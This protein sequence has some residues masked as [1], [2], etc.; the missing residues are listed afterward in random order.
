[1][2]AEGRDICNG[3]DFMKRNPIRA[4]AAA[5][6][7]LILLSA[8]PGS[9]SASGGADR[10][11]L[12]LLAGNPN[13]YPLEYYD[14]D[15]ECFSGILPLIMERVAEETGL[16]FRY[17]NEGVGQTQQ[18]IAKNKQADIL[19]AYVPDPDTEEY[20]S[21][22]HTVMSVPLDG[23]TV[24][25]CIAY[26]TIASPELIERVNQAL[27]KLTQEDLA[28]IVIS[29]TVGREAPRSRI[30]PLILMGLGL[31]LAAVCI[32]VLLIVLIKR[33]HR[34][35]ESS[36]TD[37]STGLGNKA[38]FE[39]YYRSF[40]TD[41]NRS[42]YHVAY[43]AFD[44][45]WINQYL[46]TE[47]AEVILKGT[48]TVIRDHARDTDIPA[49]VS[50]GGFG[51]AYLCDNE[52]DAGQ[53]MQELLNLLKKEFAD[54][55]VEFHAGIYSL[56]TENCPW[57]TALTNAEQG[58]H[59]ARRD[60]VPYVFST[61]DILRDAEIT[62]RLQEQTAAGVNNREFRSYLQMTV[63]ACTEKIVGA[64]M[65]SRWQNP[66]YGLLTPGQYIGIME[67]AGTIVDLDFY[68]FEEAC[69][70]LTRCAESGRRDFHIS[71]NFSRLTISQPDFTCRLF[72]I[73]SRYEFPRDRFIMEIT[74]DVLETNK[75]TALKNARECKDFGFRLALD[76]MG[77]GYTSFVNLCEYPIDVVKLDRSIIVSAAE[78]ERGAIMVNAIITMA[79]HMGMTVTC[80]GVETDVQDRLVKQAGTDLIQGFRYSRVIPLEETDLYLRKH[81]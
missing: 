43:V 58:Y 33:K 31:V 47:T 4:V 65:L 76:D 27:S 40:I 66:D 19:T 54:L 9:A 49:R 77:S 74:E 11:D 38:Y 44:I 42:L 20:L 24:D 21:C 45:R 8:L 7:A 78:M 68:M 32:V 22:T 13:L 23:K 75:E 16:I 51:L 57:D 3:G 41:H 39:Q 1:M 14:L 80:E 46:G 6:C 36:L 61:K 67:E 72:D 2:T 18:H 37:R 30:V 69:R 59:R 73:A 64:E 12:I 48:A 56:G 52:V 55:S 29:Y 53:Y 71:C 25:V 50:G 63:D 34:E 15:E 79:H 70:Y 35:S 62:Q 5:L 60:K 17:M 26:T 28:N 81:G 10:G